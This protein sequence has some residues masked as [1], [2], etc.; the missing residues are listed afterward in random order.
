MMTESSLCLPNS[1][2]KLCARLTAAYPAARLGD[3]GAHAANVRLR[4]NPRLRAVHKCGNVDVSLFSPA[5]ACR[6]GQIFRG[7]GDELLQKG[8][9]AG[10][11]HAGGDLAI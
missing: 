9:G 3:H 10:T 7:D 1:S 8:L 6:M 4:R 2:R 5:R 11:R